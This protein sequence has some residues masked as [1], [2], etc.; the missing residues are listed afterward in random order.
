MSAPEVLT[1]ILNYKTAAMTLRS[2]EAARIAM[3]DLPGEIVIVDND[4][5]DGSFETLRDHVASEGW[6]HVRVLQSG[7]NGGYGAGNNVGIRA[8][9]SD[10]SKPGYIYILNSDAF[11]DQGAIRRLI[12]HLE[13]T[14]EAGIAGSVSA[15]STRFACTLPVRIAMAIP[16]PLNG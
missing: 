13:A 10:G 5:Q 16:L 14:P 15:W 1:I 3:Q 12:A 4:S 9:L 6:D 7:H 11:P 8:G 2:A